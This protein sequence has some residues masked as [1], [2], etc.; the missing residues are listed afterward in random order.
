MKFTDGFWQ[1]RPGVQSLFAQ[2]AH[3]VEASAG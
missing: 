3:D 1:T 2:E